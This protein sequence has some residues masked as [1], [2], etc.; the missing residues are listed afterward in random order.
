[1]TR[2]AGERAVAVTET[3]GAM[4]VPGLMADIPCVS[5][6]GIVIEI[7]CLTMARAAK[8]TDLDCR[9]P[10]GVL[11]GSSAAGFGVSAPGP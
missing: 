2:Q 8:G 3:G 11:N 5:P 4:Q 6:I 9:K 10:P 7:A 1:M